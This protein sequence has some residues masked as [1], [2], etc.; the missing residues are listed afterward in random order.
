MTACSVFST[1]E[2]IIVPS[3]YCLKKSSFENYLIVADLRIVEQGLVS[4]SLAV[5]ELLAVGTE[6]ED[7]TKVKIN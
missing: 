5:P 6:G 1:G 7:V 2:Y 4:R 3:T